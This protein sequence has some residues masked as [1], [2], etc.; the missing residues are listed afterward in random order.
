MAKREELFVANRGGVREV[1]CDGLEISAVEVTVLDRTVGF[2][3]GSAIR[4]DDLRAQDGEVLVANAA[5]GGGVVGIAAGVASINSVVD[6]R[7]LDGERRCTVTD[8]PALEI[9]VLDD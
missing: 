8:H 4:M 5:V 1:C 2:A 3:V 9:R 6:E 7:V